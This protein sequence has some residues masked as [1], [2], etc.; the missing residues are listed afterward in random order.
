[1]WPSQCALSSS[2]QYPAAIPELDREAWGSFTLSL[3]SIMTTPRVFHLHNRTT[4]ASQMQ[5][6]IRAA[7]LGA[8]G[9][10]GADLLRLGVRHPGLQFVALTANTHAGKPMS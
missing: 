1:A 9:Y 6:P 8:S 10:T 2:P 5:P 7:L 4:R 3:Q